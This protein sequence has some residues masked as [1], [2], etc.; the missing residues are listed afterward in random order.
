MRRTIAGT[1]ASLFAALAIGG[2]LAS[3][4]HSAP[5]TL[6]C[7]T[8][9]SAECALLDDLAEQ[10]GPIAPLLGTVSSLAGEAQNLAAL[11]QQPS[12]VSTAKV[13]DVS[14][15]LLAKLGALPGPVQTVVGAARL[16]EV[17]DTL[18]ALVAKLTAPVAP[19][20]QTSSGGST[21]TPA[22]TA[23]APIAP[24]TT[25]GTRANDTGR[26]STAPASGG[27]TSSARVPDVP[28]GDPLTL[29]PLAL[30]EFG[31]DPSFAP[32][33][34]A[35]VAAPSAD[36]AKAAAITEAMAA[37]DSHLPEV[38]VVAILSALLL[39]AAGAAQ[40]QANR[41]QIPD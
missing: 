2:P 22:K 11:S 36:A 17:T 28:V 25:G 8:A 10:L 24:A 6:H 33:A 16:A 7:P 21:A 13:V 18:E 32:G 38:A 39:A 34:T 5:T 12:G 4:G 9:G 35:E 15:S 29:A 23:P 20:P 1:A 27:S 37:G 41:H 31:F 19:A 40:L 26:A 30:P 3:V 14:E